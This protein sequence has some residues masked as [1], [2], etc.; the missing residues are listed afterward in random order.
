M[1]EHDRLAC[2]GRPCRRGE[3]PRRLAKQ[4]DDHCD[5]ARVRILD[6]IFHVILDAARRLV[7][8][9]NGIGEAKAPAREGHREHRGHRPGLGDEAN[10]EPRAQPIA[11]EFD[12][13]QRNAVD[14]I[15]EA[16]AIRPLDRYIGFRCD[17]R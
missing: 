10:A 6:K 9:R 12:E 14:E 11:G 15:D 17:P 13:G 4:L 2:G 8:G 1:Q 16:E 3:K 5:R 7:A